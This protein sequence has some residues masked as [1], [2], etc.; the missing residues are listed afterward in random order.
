MSIFWIIY[1]IT[2]GSI[3]LLTGVIAFLFNYDDN[4]IS[5]SYV[6]LV[7]LLG[8]IPCANI[9][10]GIAFIVMV[11]IGLADEDLTPKF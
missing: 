10:C 11:L 1:F 5:I 9:L 4:P 8:A 2:L 7:D 3:I 6:V